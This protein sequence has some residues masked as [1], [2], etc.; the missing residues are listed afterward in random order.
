MNT[1]DWILK[2]PGLWALTGF[3]G[4]GIITAIVAILVFR[5][6]GTVLSQA[7]DRLVEIQTKQLELM[8]VTLNMQKTHYEDELKTLRAERQEYK[9]ALHASREEWNK[10][11]VRMQLTIQELE[12]RPNMT[13]VGDMIRRA[14]E[15]LEDLVTTLNNHDKQMQEYAKDFKKANK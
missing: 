4:G 1:A 7:N 10:E 3:V 11:S 8:E 5:R 15:L 2:F 9:D 6:Y 13:T 12:S 14:L